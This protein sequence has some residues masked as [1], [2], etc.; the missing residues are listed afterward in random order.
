MHCL[1]VLLHGIPPSPLLEWA[2]DTTSCDIAARQVFDAMAQSLSR[3]TQFNSIPLVCGTLVL[4]HLF[5]AE[6]DG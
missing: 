5:Y 3:L 2:L 1:C 4:T 6:D